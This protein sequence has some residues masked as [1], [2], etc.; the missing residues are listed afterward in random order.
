MGYEL[1]CLW[2]NG[3]CYVSMSTVAGGHC[4]HTIP[5]LNKVADMETG[6]QHLIARGP[7]ILYANCQ[8]TKSD[9]KMSVWTSLAKNMFLW[10]P[11]RHQSADCYLFGFLLQHIIK[12]RGFP[13]L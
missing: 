11:Q 10:V 4:T 6:K 5:Y 13:P 1:H 9:L 7:R 12:A 3:Y 8:V 2:H